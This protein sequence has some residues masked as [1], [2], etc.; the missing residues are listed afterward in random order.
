[1]CG[2]WRVGDCKEG[3]KF[4][5]DCCSISDDEELLLFVEVMDVFYVVIKSSLENIKKYSICN[6]GGGVKG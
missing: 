1:M 4:L 5:I 6:V 3:N 2:C